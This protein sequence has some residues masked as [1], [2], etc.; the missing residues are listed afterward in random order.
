MRQFSLQ[1]PYFQVLIE[2]KRLFKFVSFK[3]IK[4]DLIAPS[5]LS[6]GIVFDSKP[7]D[8]QDKLKDPETGVDGSYV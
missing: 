3:L 2:V 6:N 7:V 5:T 8:C 1:S 4:A